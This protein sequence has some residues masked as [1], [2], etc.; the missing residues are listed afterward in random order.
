MSKNMKMVLHISGVAGIGSLINMSRH[1]HHTAKT[2]DIGQSYYA[3]RGGLGSRLNEYYG[4]RPFKNMKRLLAAAMKH[5]KDF[6]IIHIHGF[7]II[8]PLFKLLGKKTILHYHGSD[9]NMKT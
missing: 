3:D 7:E 2:N 1:D 5:R 8:I 4:G 6:D 9:I